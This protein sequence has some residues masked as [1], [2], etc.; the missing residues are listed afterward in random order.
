MV[1]LSPLVLARAL[2]LFPVPL[3]PLDALHLASIEFLRGCRLQP[4]LASYDEP[5]AGGANVGDRPPGARLSGCSRFSACAQRRAPR[6]RH[7]F[8]MIG[9]AIVRSLAP[10]LSPYSPTQQVLADL[11]RAAALEPV[12]T[13]AIELP[14]VF[15]DGSWS[16]FPGGQVRRAAACRWPRRAR[17]GCAR[18]HQALTTSPDGH[19]F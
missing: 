11:W 7:P 17:R 2:E 5:F 18:Q 6:Q 16:P 13:R 4:R 19:V 15:T 12:Q 1:E 3:R 8:S 10:F 9:L 14:I